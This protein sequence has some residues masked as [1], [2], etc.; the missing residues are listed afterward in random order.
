MA[1]SLLFVVRIQQKDSDDPAINKD[2][3]FTIFQDLFLVNV[4][5]FSAGMHS[6]MSARFFTKVKVGCHTVVEEPTFR[7]I[8]N[9]SV[10]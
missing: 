9:T 8:L 7:T 6:I 10:P 2:K 5:I 1:V 4:T 3:Y